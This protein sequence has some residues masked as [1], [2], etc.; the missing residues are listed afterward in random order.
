MIQPNNFEA[1]SAR[2]LSA[3]SLP[4]RAAEPVEGANPADDSQRVRATS[5]FDYEPRVPSTKRDENGK[6]DEDKEPVSDG[7]NK[8]TSETTPDAG[9]PQA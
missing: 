1:N 8:L 4:A 9:P 2:R 5:D 7:I 6:D 3:S